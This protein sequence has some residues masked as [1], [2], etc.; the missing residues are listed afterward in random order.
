MEHI[1]SKDVFLQMRDTLKRIHKRPMDHGFKVAY[2]VYRMLQEKGGFEEFELADIVMTATL[3]DIGAYKTDAKSLNDMLRYETKDCK[4]HSVY[5]Y[6]IFKHISPL[7]DYAKVLL[8]HHTDFEHLKNTGYAYADLAAFINIAETMEIYSFAMGPQ[9]DM[10]M[11][12]KQ[13][14][15]KFSGNG[16]TLFYE[17]EKKYGMLE[18]IRSGAYEQDLN[19]ILDYMI[20]NNEDEEKLRKMLLYCESLEKE[21]K[22]RAF[23]PSAEIADMQR[24]LDKQFDQMSQRYKM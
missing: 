8:H 10:Q 1:E 6:L 16:L 18:N 14:D 20:F 17:C 23:A 13:A 9:F 4:A 2:M 21:S 19:E 3:H 24:L 22:G 15:R 7:P 11:F 12:Q 5:G